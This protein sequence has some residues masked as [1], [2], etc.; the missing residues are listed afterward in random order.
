MS[1]LLSG[2]LLL[3]G[4][5]LII[6]PWVGWYS[7]ALPQYFDTSIGLIILAFA[8]VQISRGE[9]KPRVKPIDIVSFFLGVALVLAG[10]FWTGRYGV[11]IRVGEILCGLLIILPSWIAWHLPPPSTAK[12]FSREGQPMLEVQSLTFDQKGLGIKGK[13]MGTM[14][15][16]IYLRPEE[17][18]KLLALVPIQIVWQVLRIL[19]I[20]ESG[21]ESVAKG[22]N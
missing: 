2:I 10:I 11:V 9:Q 22:G 21:K 14:P 5:W 18:W 16:T 19:L 15:S 8:L 6:A 7:D 12:M 13:L 4:L 17:L 20:P 3:P 1:L